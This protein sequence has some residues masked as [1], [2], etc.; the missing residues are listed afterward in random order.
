MRYYAR[1]FDLDES[2]GYVPPGGFVKIIIESYATDYQLRASRAGKLFEQVPGAKV[3]YKKSDGD[4]FKINVGDELRF[5]RKKL[6][7]FP[8]NEEVR[9]LVKEVEA[10]ATSAAR[11]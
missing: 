1:G 10:L 4:L 2:I 5:S 6:G 11:Q 7:R 8:T 9:A 3:A